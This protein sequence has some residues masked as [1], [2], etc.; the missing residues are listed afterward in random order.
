MIRTSDYDNLRYAGQI[1]GQIL[2]ALRDAL[3]PGIRTIELDEIAQQMQRDAGAEAPFLGYPA[4]GEHP[5]PATINVSVNEELVHGIPGQRVI[6]ED[7]VVTLDC[8]TQYNGLIADSAITVAVGEVSSQVRQLIEGTETALDIATKI[9][10]PGRY[11]GDVAFAIQSVLYKYAVTIPPQFGGHGVGYSLHESP[12]MP[13]WGTPGKGPMLRVG[14]ALA[15]EPMGM[16]GRQETRLL[17]DHWTVVSNDGSICSHFEHTVL[18]TENGAE[19]L[20]PVP[21]T[22][23]TLDG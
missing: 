7:D 10:G 20:T 5:Y 2:A 3:R 8:G 4:G 9:A 22:E 14:M 15:I 23:V 18:I 16:L 12:H 21:Q 17:D 1:N 13:N 6:R 11:V 19:I